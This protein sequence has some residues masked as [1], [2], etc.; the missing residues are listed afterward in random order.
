MPAIS[1]LF[2][3]PASLS[4]CL[5]AGILRDT[6]GVILSDAD[7]INHFPASPLVSVTQVLCGELRLLPTSGDW[8]NVADTLP[9]PS[10]SVMGPN[11]S[12]VSSWAA[13]ECAAFTVGFY[14]D[15]WL[16]L[17]GAAGFSHVPG[18]IGS[19]LQRFCAEQDP[20]DGW[21]A[22]CDAL[23]PV[24]AEARP[25]LMGIADWAKTV[26]TRAALSGSGRSLRSVER[27]I[28]R[29]SGQTRRA[30][31]FYGSF[32]NLHRVTQQ[33][34]E[35]SLAEIAQEA[36]YADQSHMGRSV[37]RATGFSPA[38]L[39]RAIKSDEAFWCYRLLGE[40]F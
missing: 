21:R 28:R 27:R 17:G 37:R 18:S 25:A 30:L 31:E 26:T 16:I 14:H 5:F 9:L 32:E 12:P 1:K 4:G 6:R 23:A 29:T 20:A 39:N 34:P 22:F 38:R 3:P 35:T 40:R 36:G 15:A 19:A 11:V 2:L 33:H 24:W 7:R 13:G 8:C 10:T